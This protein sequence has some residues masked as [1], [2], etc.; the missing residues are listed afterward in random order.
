MISVIVPIYNVETYLEKC[1]DSIISQT[2]RDLEI[3]L[4]DDGSS[5][6]CPIICD[7]YA[8]MDNRIRVIHKSNG[9]L[10]DARNAG[11]DIATGD[12]ISFIDSDD[13]IE[14]TM[15]E[16]MENTIVKNDADICI[17]GYREVDNRGV[18]FKTIA[19]PF[20]K[21]SRQEAFSYLM[22][23]N[24]YY[25]IMCN[26]LFRKRIFEKKYRFQVG[27]IHEDEFMIHYLYGECDCIVSMEEVFYNYITRSESIMHLQRLSNREFDDVDVYIDRA[28]FFQN[29]QLKEYAAQLLCF[30]PDDCVR[31]YQL[32]NHNAE[33]KKRVKLIQSDLKNIYKSIDVGLL[34]WFRKVG[35]KIFMVSFHS[36]RI[37]NRAISAVEKIKAK[38]I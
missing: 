13:F 7:K 2:Y 17:C 26:K 14:S 6:K 29:I 9:G 15:L 5:D 27:R 1:I 3:I 30:I 10:S 28:L 11:L 25:A 4:V 22:D 31:V 35:I 8:K 37:W 36:Y 19:Q 32:V 18:T 33:T 16:A 20:R 21:I 34:K 24:V 38:S 23:G 12:F